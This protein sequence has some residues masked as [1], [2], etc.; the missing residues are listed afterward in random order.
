[1]GS[2]S[3][4]LFYQWFGVDLESGPGMPVFCRLLAAILVIG[5]GWSFVP[6]LRLLFIIIAFEKLVEKLFISSS[7]WIWS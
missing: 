2:E 7:N 6:R 3:E 5:M 4:M 1:M